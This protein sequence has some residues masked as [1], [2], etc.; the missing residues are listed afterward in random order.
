MPN[1]VLLGEFA[2]AAVEAKRVEST[3]TNSAPAASSSQL[4]DL[5]DRLRAELGEGVLVEAS[6]VVGTFNAI[7]KVADMTGCQLDRMTEEGS[8]GKLAIETMNLADLA[9]GRGVRLSTGET[10]GSAGMGKPTAR[11]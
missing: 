10:N 8:A 1:G 7:T 9:N 11:L 2:K 5:R 6:A 4:S 3:A